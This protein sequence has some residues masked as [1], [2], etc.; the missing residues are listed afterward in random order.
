MPLSWTWPQIFVSF[1]R[2]VSFIVHNM[3]V[4]AGGVR[5]CH[6]SAQHVVATGAFTDDA[7]CTQPSR[8]LPNWASTLFGSPPELHGVHAYGELDD[9]VRP[10]TYPAGTTWPNI[11][12]SAR[13]VRPRISTAAFFSWPPLKLLLQPTSVLNT[14]ELRFCSSC[15][16]CLRVEPRLAASYA[17]ALKKQR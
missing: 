15:E 16:A 11:F 13:A 14:T 12:A 5:C 6:S 3:G 17:A 8:S 10:A 7:R 1:E 2:T 4:H 9:A